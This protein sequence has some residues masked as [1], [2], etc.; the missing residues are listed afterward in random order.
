M[1]IDN[2]TIEFL[3]EEAEFYKKQLEFM[4]TK[5]LNL[6]SGNNLAQSLGL[7]AMRNLITFPKI[8][9]I[10]QHEQKKINAHHAAVKTKVLQQLHDWILYQNK[11]GEA[12]EEEDT[13]HCDVMVLL[14]KYVIAQNHFIE[15]ETATKFE[16]LKLLKSKLK[17]DLIKLNTK[18]I[19]KGVIVL[20]ET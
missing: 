7:A 3:E 8:D 18:L 6:K 17:D 16:I 4:S 11:V 15:G 19:Q 10:L 5:Q 12:E 9:F 20:D 1:D 13:H 14:Q 2:A